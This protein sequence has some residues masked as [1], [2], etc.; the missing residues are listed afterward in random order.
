VLCVQISPC[1]TTERLAYAPTGACPR[2]AQDS[3]ANRDDL[4]VVDAHELVSWV[5]QI[6]VLSLLVVALLWAIIGCGSG[7]DGPRRSAQIERAAAKLR[8]SIKAEI[9]ALRDHRWAGEYYHG[10]GLGV[11]VSFIVASKAGYLFEWH[12]CLGLS[13]SDEMLEG[14]ITQIGEEE[15]EPRIGWKLS[16]RC[17]W[18]MN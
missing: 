12:G 3:Q 1:R 18:N 7:D 11:N 9:V 4:F 8:D 5:K 6:Q 15:E 14:V 13:V 17:P 2:G 10:D 16:T